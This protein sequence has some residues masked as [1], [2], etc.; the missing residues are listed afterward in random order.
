MFEL[1]SKRVEYQI[2]IQ[3][4]WFL[5]ESIDI[6]Y[7]ISCNASRV[8]FR[9]YFFSR[10]DFT[11]EQIFRRQ[12]YLS[13]WKSNSVLTMLSNSIKWFILFPTNNVSEFPKQS[14]HEL[15]NIV[16]VSLMEI[17]FSCR[18]MDFLLSSLVIILSFFKMESE[19]LFNQ[20][21]IEAIKS[22]VCCLMLLWF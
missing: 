19:K 4:E 11:I 17:Q 16:A 22:R 9:N 15:S 1:N 14:I 10:V 21:H 18:K 20:P 6:Y 3:V 5:I 2:F 8:F 13:M 12:T 7:F